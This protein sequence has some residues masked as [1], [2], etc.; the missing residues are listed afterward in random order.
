MT[1]LEILAVKLTDASVAEM[2]R[3]L[4]LA[5]IEQEILNYCNISAVPPQLCFVQANMARDL[6]LYEQELN[7]V[8]DDGDAGEAALSG[9]VSSIA[10]GDTTVSFGN[11]SDAEEDRARL[12]GS[13]REM[14]DMLIL[15]YREQLNKFRDFRRPAKS[16]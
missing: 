6:L 8:P 16:Q 14:L 7:R 10:E 13:H 3:L 15:N 5:E 2:Q 1:A 4:A 11:K 9:K 12:L